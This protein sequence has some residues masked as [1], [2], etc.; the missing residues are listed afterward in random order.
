MATYRPGSNTL[1][2]SDSILEVRIDSRMCKRDVRVQWCVF[3]VRFFGGR[4][5][6]NDGEM[7]ICVCTLQYVLDTTVYP[8]EHERL[9]ELRL[10]TQNH[11]KC[12]A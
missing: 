12:V 1:L 4:D 8:R 7:H 11:P 2:K 9:R 3:H 5:Q 10:I 6:K